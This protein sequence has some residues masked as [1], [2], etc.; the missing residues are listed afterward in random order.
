MKRRDGEKARGREERER[1]K[2]RER[3]KKGG[4]EGEK[5]GEQAYLVFKNSSSF[6]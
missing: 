3:G 4:R 6:P 5:E 1:R 2:R